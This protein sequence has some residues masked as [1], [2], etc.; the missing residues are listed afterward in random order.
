MTLSDIDAGSIEAGTVD[1]TAG[2]AAM[3]DAHRRECM[4]N[5]RAALAGMDKATNP[6]E[7]RAALAA[8]LDW[9][10]EAGAAADGAAA[11]RGLLR[12]CPR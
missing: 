4:E 12:E 11:L 5:A 7:W 2:M 10:R 6:R 3:L 1:A 9:T 8:H